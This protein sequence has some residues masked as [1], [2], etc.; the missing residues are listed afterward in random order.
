M[1]K[2]NNWIAIIMVIITVPATIVAT[3]EIPQF[4]FS[5]PP[6]VA[7]VEVFP[8]ESPREPEVMRYANSL[9]NNLNA[10]DKHFNHSPEETKQQE[11]I[12][13]ALA[14]LQASA[15]EK[16]F[17]EEIKEALANTSTKLVFEYIGY[18][19]KLHSQLD[20]FSRFREYIKISIKN[21]GKEIVRGA[22][23]EFPNSL[24]LIEI[25]NTSKDKK[26]IRNVSTIELGQLRPK[27]EITIQAW[28][29]GNRIRGLKTYM[30]VTKEIA[31][32]IILTHEG[33][34][35]IGKI[36]P[37][38]SNSDSIRISEIDWANRVKN[39]LADFAIMIP[40][41]FLGYFLFNFA[42]KESTKKD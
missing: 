13:L 6:L 36:V 4:L 38:I 35:G 7:Y 2:S 25:T 41:F 32:K 8:V 18:D 12:T 10:I 29:N 1:N 14:L 30:N 26:I 22:K 33:E 15:E 24:S 20:S 37:I 19:A 39:R 42:T 28:G 31:N 11:R 17:S 9:R 3:L 34:N 16:E 40:L 23:I 21:E 5:E 27:K